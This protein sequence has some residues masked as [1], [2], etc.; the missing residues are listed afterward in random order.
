MEFLKVLDLDQSFN[1]ELFSRFVTMVMTLGC[2]Y[3]FIK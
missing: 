1:G 3:L 2:I